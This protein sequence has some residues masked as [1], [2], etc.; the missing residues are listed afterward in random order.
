MIGTITNVTA[1]I[2]GTLIGSL[3]RK[4]I[5][6]EYHGAMLNAMGLAATAL[7]I[8]REYV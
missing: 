4:G 8:C 3:F 2:L 6:P 7:G 5:K 1:I